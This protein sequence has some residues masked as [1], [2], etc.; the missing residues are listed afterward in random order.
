MEKHLKVIETFI[1]ET[2]REHGTVS[3]QMALLSLGL[4]RE[5]LDELHHEISV[6]NNLLDDHKHLLTSIPSCPIHG[7]TCIP[8]AIEWVRQVKTF[9]EVIFK[10]G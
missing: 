10:H 7:E 5:G 3:G 4:I 2:G 6:D 8:H 1:M 9:G